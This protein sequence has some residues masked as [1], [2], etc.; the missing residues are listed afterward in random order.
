[1][2]FVALFKELRRRRMFRGAGIYV[3]GAWLILQVTDVIAE[4]LGLPAGTMTLLLYM[5]ILGFPLAL[6]LSW[7]Y[8]LTEEGLARTQS[9]PGEDVTPEELALGGADYGIFAALTLVVVVMVYGLVSGRAHILEITENPRSAELVAPVELLPN[10]IAVLPF[11]DM[12]PA[13]DQEYFADGLADTLLHVLAQVQGLKVAART[14]SFAFK[15]KNENIVNI[16]RQLGVSNVLEG[17]VQKSGNQLRVIAQLIEAQHGTHLW[18]G[19]FDGHLDDVFSIQDEISVEVVKALEIALLES[20]A[21]RLIDRYR[22]DLQAYDQL[23]LGRH[24]MSRGTIGGLNAA[25]GHFRQAIELDANYPLPYVYLADTLGLLEIY[26]LGI[27]DTFSG[28]STAV[29]RAEQK[30]L[31]DR[32]LELDPDAGEAHASLAAILVDEQLAEEHFQRAIE[33]SPNYAKAYL[34][35]SKYLSI[36]RGRYPDALTQIEKALELDPLSDTIRHE[37]AKM[38]WAVGRVE[39]AVTSMMGYVRQSPGFPPFYKRMVRWQAQLGEMGEA[40]RW[41]QALRRLEPSSPTHWGEWGGECWVWSALGDDSTAET[42]SAEFVEAHPGSIMARRVVAERQAIEQ[43]GYGIGGMYALYGEE[44]KKAWQPVTQIYEDMIAVEPGNDYRANQFASI[45]E[46]AG[47]YDRL[48]EVMAVAHPQFFTDSAEV[49]G[50]TTWPATMTINALQKL[51]REE[52]AD[53]LLGVFEKGIAGMRMITGPGFSN[54]IENVELAAFR[55]DKEEAIGLFRKAVDRDWKFMWNFTP[56]MP[57]LSIMHDDPRFKA[58]YEDMAEEIAAQRQW[59]EA[60]K[61]R[62]LFEGAP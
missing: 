2:N 24:Q 17:S 28:L 31:V 51:G 32:A 33:L 19:T 12:S 35:Y 53:R 4:P 37:Y 50:E 22:P 34:W 11:A 56:Y 52:E 43:G 39:E 9:H 14:S 18:S 15:G 20:D 42:C 26:D 48:V 44:R 29:T 60:N 49:T 38:V 40:M 55:G 47:M 30:L 7:R 25:A 27:Q 45:L 1:M 10:S 41:V 13:K 59:Y 5:I 62:P 58:M 23:V 57:S 8:E 6:F 16:A 61:E 36:R 46:L 3:V 21:E 54:G